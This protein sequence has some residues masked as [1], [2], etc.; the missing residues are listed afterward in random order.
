M[1]LCCVLTRS[2]EIRVLWTEPQGNWVSWKKE[3]SP[4]ILNR[5]I[6]KLSRWVYGAVIWY[7]L[8]K[9]RCPL[10][11][12]HSSSFR[13]EC[14]AKVFP[15]QFYSVLRWIWMNGCLTCHPFIFVSNL[16]FNHE[17]RIELKKPFFLLYFSLNF[18]NSN[19]DSD[20]FPSILASICFLCTIAGW[21]G[22]V[23]QKKGN[24]TRCKFI[25]NGKLLGPLF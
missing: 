20:I 6:V 4:N 9:F 25:S 11:V 5:G 23:L 7:S 2:E 13:S 18:D 15:E 17:S 12:N 16:T 3:I 1:Q 22:L 21:H 19:T 10:E 8:H 14:I 24:P